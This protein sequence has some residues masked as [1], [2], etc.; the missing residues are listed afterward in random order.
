MLIVDPVQKT[1]L[2]L[3]FIQG[4]VLG[5]AW[6]LSVSLIVTKAAFVLGTS[7]YLVPGDF[8]Q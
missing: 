4:H 5:A 8:K 2:S 7:Q 6:A 1:A 3:A